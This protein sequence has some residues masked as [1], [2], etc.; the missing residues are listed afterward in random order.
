ETEVNL[1]DILH[2]LKTIV[3]GQIHAKQLELYMDTLDVVDED[4]YCDKI[5][6]NQVLLNLL[7]NAVKFTAPGGTVSVRVEQLKNA[8]EGKGLYEFR[9]KDTGIGMSKDFAEKIFNPFERERTSTVSRIQGTGL[10]MSIAKNIIDLMGGTIEVN[11]E[12]GKGT[13]F[14]IR[15]ELRLQSEH[16]SVEKIKELEGLKALVVDDDFNTCDSVTKMLLRVGMRS[17]WTVSGKEAVLRARQAIEVNDEFHAYIIDWRLPDMN[18]IEVTRQ[19]RSL[20][21]H[22]P[23]IILTAYDWTD[24]EVEARAAGVTAF[25]SKPMFMSD[26][27]ESLLNALGHQ[28]AEE[29]SI[30]PVTDETGSFKG[31]RLLLVEDNELNREIA[32][33]IL[34][35]Y[36]LIVDT[37]ENGKIAVDTITASKAGDYDLVLMDIQMPVM[38]GYEATRSIRKLKNTALSSVPIVAMTANAFDEDRKAAEECGMNG[39]ISKPINMEEVIAALNSVFSKK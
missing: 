13:E 25:C 18:G 34:N 33:E 28:K 3:S 36:G 24:I 8:A 5:R 22:T 38:D 12:Q 19:I 26:L 21:D 15:M 29:E 11:T 32:F 16:R 6:L 1:S 37:A 30:L 35:E 20:G 27:R 23:I 39:F 2:D 9:V 4:V 7:S 14:V 10:G 31:K 17:E